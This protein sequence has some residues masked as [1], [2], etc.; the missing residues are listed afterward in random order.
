M[1][2]I[3]QNNKYANILK[4]KCAREIVVPKVRMDSFVTFSVVKVRNFP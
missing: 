1:Q 4:A 3:E 2:K